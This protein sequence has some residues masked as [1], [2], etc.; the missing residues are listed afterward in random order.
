MAG[1]RQRI[2]QQNKRIGRA[3]LTACFFSVLFC[4]KAP[5]VT[6]IRCLPSLYFAGPS[7]KKYV[8]KRK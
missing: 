2:Q 1:Y 6:G 3:G 5:N 4:V 8:R 7:L